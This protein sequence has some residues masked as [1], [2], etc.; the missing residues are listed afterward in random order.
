MVT[1][2]NY[3]MLLY[4]S[5]PY[6]WPLCWLG[7]N[8]KPRSSKD[9]S[10]FPRGSVKMGGTVPLKSIIYFNLTSS[11]RKLIKSDTKTHLQLF[12]FLFTVCCVDVLSGVCYLTFINIVSSN[13]LS[14]N[15]TYVQVIRAIQQN[16]SKSACSQ[17]T[18][19]STHSHEICGYFINVD[20][21]CDFNE[22]DT[23]SQ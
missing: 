1:L 12:I 7:L 4:I 17:L 2:P 9:G 15:N 10:S 14:C 5:N 21:P 22:N 23:F 11:D 18:D 3:S 19:R 16:I 20:E 8:F 13:E 6:Y